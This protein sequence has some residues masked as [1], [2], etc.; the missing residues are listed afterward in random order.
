MKGILYIDNDIISEVDFKVIDE[1]MGGIG[2]SLP[3][4]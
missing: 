4:L 3:T 1:S 2:G